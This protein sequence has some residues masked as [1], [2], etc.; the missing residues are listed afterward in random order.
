MN[1]HPTRDSETARQTGVTLVY[2]RNRETVACERQMFILPHLPEDNASIPY[3][4]PYRY[5]HTVIIGSLHTH[6][7]PTLRGVGYAVTTTPSPPNDTFSKSYRRD[8]SNV[9]L[10]GTCGCLH[11]CGVFELRKSVRG[12]CHDPDGYGA[13]RPEQS[14][15]LSTC[16]RTAWHASWG[17]R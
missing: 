13:T 10:F 16:P 5:V 4:P 9:T 12:A 11:C 15:E 2:L 1:V 6:P 8:L 7:E 14:S 17:L 3:I